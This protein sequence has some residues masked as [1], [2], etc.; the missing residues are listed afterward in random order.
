MKYKVSGKTQ[1]WIDIVVEAED[2]EQAFDM[3]AQKIGSLTSFC[4]NGG[5]DK[6]VGIYY[7]EASIEPSDEIEWEEASPID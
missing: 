4:G 3:A 1:V 2:E 7:R 6:L 5:S